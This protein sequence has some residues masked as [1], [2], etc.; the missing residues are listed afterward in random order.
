MNVEVAALV[1]GRT[2]R[3]D[4]IRLKQRP[5]HVVVGTPGRVM[6][7]IKDRALGRFAF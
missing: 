4:V 1:G 5:A 6:H 2:V 7:M 3:D